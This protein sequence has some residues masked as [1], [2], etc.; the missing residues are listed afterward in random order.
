M[1]YRT[2]ARLLGTALALSGTTVFAQT[3][4]YVDVNHPV[5]GVGTQ[6]DPFTSITAALFNP[7]LTSGDS[8]AVA[9]GTYAEDIVFGG[10]ASGLHLYSLEGPL[11]TTIAAATPTSTSIIFDN[12][13]LV[14]GFTLQGSG[15]DSTGTFCD[16]FT[17]GTLRECI[18]RGYGTACDNLY[19]LFLHSS[20]VSFNDVGVFHWGGGHGAESLTFFNSSILWGNGMDAKGLDI[21]GSSWFWEHSLSTDPD[22]WSDTDLH[23]RASS[24]GINTGDPSS[25]LDPDGSRSDIG[26][27]PYDGNYP[28]GTTYC[29]ANEN[30][31]GARGRIELSG[32]G[33]VSA[34]NLGL[35]AHGLPGGVVSLFF[36]GT[37]MVDAPLGNGRLCAGGQIGRLGV[38]VANGAGI[39]SHAFD[40]TS[41][42]GGA[43]AVA[44][45]QT[46][47]FQNWFRDVPG[48]GE[49][50]NLTNAVA[51]PFSP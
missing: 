48:G 47:T 9:P 45:G 28:V 1:K 12:Y 38:E 37:Q 19:D 15:S 8:I 26:A 44:A 3:T 4:W 31:S 43:P 6:A 51:V 42:M 24:T 20:T 30:S 50:S 49:E 40:N 11:V 10:S 17:G 2:L 16:Y 33:R 5:S 36:I 32:T 23:L 13:E 22:F 18:V 25:P 29:L 39:A 35:S 41:A 21:W 7:T 46:R 27:I 34:N 14:E